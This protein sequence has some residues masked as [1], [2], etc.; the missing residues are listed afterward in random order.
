MKENLSIFFFVI[1][2]VGVY[3]SPE[4]K[5]QWP[6]G[7][8][9]KVAKNAFCKRALRYQFQEKTQAVYRIIKK[10]EQ[11]KIYSVYKFL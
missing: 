3:M 5:R 1:G 7:C 4:Q 11:D 9:T 2:G 10:R 6:P 8:V